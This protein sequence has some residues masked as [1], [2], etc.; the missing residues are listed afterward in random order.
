[1]LFTHGNN[2]S[3]YEAET[4]WREYWVWTGNSEGWKHRT[5]IFDPQPLNRV[6]EI[7]K[8]D[9]DYGTP[10]Y[11]KRQLENSPERKELKKE[12]QRLK[13]KPVTVRI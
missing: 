5:Q 9:D 2:L 10:E 4:G 12:Y 1:M 3:G 13:K 11:Q 8:L 6:Y 7:T